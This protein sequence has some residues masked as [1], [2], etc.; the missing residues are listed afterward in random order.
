MIRAALI[1]CGK[2][3][4]GHIHAFETIDDASIVAAC[5]LSEAN[6]NHVCELTGAKP[7]TDYKKMI[8]ELKSE[9]DFAIITLPHGLHGEATCYCAERGVN[10]FLE[11]PM[12]LNSEDCQKMIDCCKKN[13]VMFWV[14]HLQKY[15]PVNIVAK[16]LIASGKLGELISF[17]ETR[18][19][20]YFSTDRPQWFTSK[21]MSGGGI[22]INLGAHSLDKLKF[23]TDAEIS[24][25]S[26]QVHMHEGSDC[27]DSGQAFVKMSNGVTATLNLIGHIPAYDYHTQ[28]YFT[29]GEIRLGGTSTVSYCCEDGVFTDIE[30]DSTPGMTLQI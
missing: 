26:G 14:G 6:L 17:H 30:V 11:K 5:D 16:E 27:E 1:G 8:D 25:I 4:S 7:Y 23:F 24:E 19:L 29:K 21:K 3:S 9:I 12:G 10:V 18:N 13:D 15:M 2:I 22:M 28:L 20:S